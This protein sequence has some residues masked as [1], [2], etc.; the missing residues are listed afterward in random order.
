MISK[1]YNVMAK[2]A[3]DLGSAA[4]FIASLTAFIIFCVIFIP[5]IINLFV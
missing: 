1:E 4:T 3:K 2:Y 5:K